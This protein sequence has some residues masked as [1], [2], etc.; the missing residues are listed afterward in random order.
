MLMTTGHVSPH[1]PRSPRNNKKNIRNARSSD[2][3]LRSMSTVAKA[4]ALLMAGGS[5]HKPARGKSSEIVINPDIVVNPANAGTGS[6]SDKGNSCD[7]IKKS[8]DDD[9]QSLNQGHKDI[10][11]VITVGTGQSVLRKTSDITMGSE[12][13]D[14]RYGSRRMPSRKPTPQPSLGDSRSSFGLEQVD[15]GVEAESPAISVRKPSTP[16]MNKKLSNSSHKQQMSSNRGYAPPPAPQTDDGPSYV[17]ED[18]DRGMTGGMVGGIEDMSLPGQNGIWG[19]LPA[20]DLV[21]QATPATVPQ[22]SRVTS[23]STGRGLM[24]LPEGNEKDDGNNGKRDGR[25]VAQAPQNKLGSDDNGEDDRTLPNIRGL[26]IRDGAM[27]GLPR[28]LSLAEYSNFSAEST[29]GPASMKRPQRRPNKKPAKSKSGNDM[30]QTYEVINRQV[31]DGHGVRGVYS[32]S[33]CSKNHVPEGYGLIRYHKGGRAYEGDWV[34][35]NWDG[36]GT[37]VVAGGDRFDGHFKEGR[38]EG[39]GKMVFVDGR[40][41]EGRFLQ[42]QMREGKLHFT[43]GSKYEGM[44]MEGKRNGYGRYDFSDE[45]HY[46]GQWKDDQMDGRGNMRWNDGGFYMGDW[47]G[48]LQ[49]GKGVEVLPNGIERHNGLWDQGCPVHNHTTVNVPA[50]F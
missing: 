43:D 20:P 40:V 48:G 6:S 38:K 50:D 33:L 16:E 13:G 31:H 42:D 28:E 14:Y 36:F 22:T 1:S 49:H 47:A 24:S 39:E 37:L 27:K 11:A 17:E 35:G 3:S 45:S 44:L 25:S 21:R 12:F 5:S 41:F 15:E 18:D 30:S 46:E 2:E 8:N 26:E 9:D 23:A 10:E 34:N 7:N 4:D 29:V 19:A 32:G